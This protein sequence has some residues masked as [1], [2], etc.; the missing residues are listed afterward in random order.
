M[1]LYLLAGIALAGLASPALAAAGP[2]EPSAT[3]SVEAVQYRPYD[4]Y[5]DDRGYRERRSYRND[6]EDDDRPRYRAYRERERMYQR[7]YHEDDD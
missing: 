1:K 3:A 5:Y 7:R 6:D 4:R 2:G